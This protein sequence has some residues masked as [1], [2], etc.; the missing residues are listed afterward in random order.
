MVSTPLYCPFVMSNI[1]A[2]VWVLWLF[3]GPVIGSLVMQWYLFLT[4]RFYNL[5]I[6]RN[7]LANSIG[8]LL[9]LFVPKLS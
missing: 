2:R 3:L 9:V 1:K 7:Q 8:S 6:Q 4:V 5:L